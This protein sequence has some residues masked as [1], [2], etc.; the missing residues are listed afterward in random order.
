MNLTNDEYYGDIAKKVRAKK[1]LKEQQ[2]REAK[3]KGNN[4]LQLT[5]AMKRKRHDYVEDSAEEP[6]QP[7]STAA[8]RKPREW[9]K[10]SPHAKSKTNRD[11]PGSK[12]SK[13]SPTKSATRT[14]PGKSWFTAFAKD[15]YL[16]AG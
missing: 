13:D 2:A 3:R 16:R 12:I 1:L 8:T 9:W 7:V 6:N 10:G 15:N 14:S 11:S 4:L 5:Q